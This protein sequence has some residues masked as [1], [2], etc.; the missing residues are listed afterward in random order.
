MS[1]PQ[2]SQDWASPKIPIS[3][4][5]LMIPASPDYQPTKTTTA[6]SRFSQTPLANPLMMSRKSK[7]RLLRNLKICSMKPHREPLASATTRILTSK[8]LKN[9]WPK[10]TKMFL[11]A[12]VSIDNSRWRLLRLSLKT[13]FLRTQK[14]NNSKTRSTWLANELAS[15][16][17]LTFG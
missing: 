8:F 11:S 1:Q 15:K 6:G 12:R 9:S 2:G 5:K 13:T 4:G 7:K 17:A 14:S 10:L 16:V 3:H